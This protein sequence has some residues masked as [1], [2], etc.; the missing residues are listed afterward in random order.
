[1]TERPGMDSTMPV[2]PSATVEDALKSKSGKSAYGAPA[3]LP[4]APAPAR[5]LTP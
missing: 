5:T 2:D 1:V 3:L 4:R